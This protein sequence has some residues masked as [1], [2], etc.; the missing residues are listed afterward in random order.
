MRHAEAVSD[1]GPS[2]LETP[3]NSAY[4]DCYSTAFEL[5]APSTP[6]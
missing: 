6:L 1:K 5:P 4:E 3:L 2:L